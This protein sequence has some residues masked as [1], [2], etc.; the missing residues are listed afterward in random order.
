MAPNGLKASGLSG[1]IS[2]LNLDPRPLWRSIGGPRPLRRC[3]SLMLVGVFLESHGICLVQALRAETAGA[4]APEVTKFEPVNTTDMVNLVTGDFAYT[5][6]VLNVPGPDGGY[7]LTLGYHAGIPHA[8]DASWVGLGWNLQAGSISRAVRGYPDDFKDVLIDINYRSNLYESYSISASYMGV[9][10]GVGYTTYMGFNGFVGYYIGLNLGLGPASVNAGVGITASFSSQ[11]SSV[12]AFAQA[13]AVLGPKSIGASTQTDT[14]G[15]SS[16]GKHNSIGVSIIQGGGANEAGPEGDNS[17]EDTD[18]AKKSEKDSGP[19]GDPKGASASFSSFN[20][21]GSHSKS[22]GLG[23]SFCGFGVNLGYSRS[24]TDKFEH[25]QAY[26]YYYHTEADDPDIEKAKLRINE[27]TMESDPTVVPGDSPTHA[28]ASGMHYLNSADGYALMGEGTGGAL[29]LTRVHDRIYRPKRV[30]DEWEEGTSWPWPNSTPQQGATAYKAR[31]VIEGD[32][33]EQ[34][35]NPGTVGVLP[36]NLSSIINDQTTVNVAQP[37]T[38]NSLQGN[39]P[40]IFWGKE[41]VPGSRVV[42]ERIGSDSGLGKGLFTGFDIWE[43][44]GKH[45]VYGEPVYQFSSTTIS[46]NRP[47]VGDGEWFRSKS[48][49]SQPYAYAWYLTELRYPDYFDEKSDGLSDDDK[50]GWVRFGYIVGCSSYP[51]HT[52]PDGQLNDGPINRIDTWGK[53]KAGMMYSMQYGTKQL[54]YLQSVETAT[55]IALFAVSPRA[56]GFGINVAGTNEPVIHIATEAVGGSSDEFDLTT[57]ASPSKFDIRI[58]NWETISDQTEVV[59]GDGPC[60]GMT[61]GTLYAQATIS[62]SQ[63]AYITINGVPLR[64][65]WIRKTD[66]YTAKTSSA[67]PDSEPTCVSGC[68]TKYTYRIKVSDQFWGKTN[69]SGPNGPRASFPE[70]WKRWDGL[71]ATDTVLKQA[72]M[73][74]LDDI[75]LLEKATGRM[76]KQVHFIYDYLLQQGTVV[77][78]ELKGFVPNT[79]R[80]M[81]DV[82]GKVLNPRGGKLTLIGLRTIGA[83]GVSDNVSVLPP[84]IFEYGKN[85]TWGNKYAFDRWGYFKSDGG[86]WNHRDVNGADQSAWCLTRITTPTGG[87]LQIQYEPKDYTRVQDRYPINP[88]ANAG[89]VGNYLVDLT[90]WVSDCPWP[91]TKDEW[92]AFLA[93]VNGN[94]SQAPT[95][96]RLFPPAG[97]TSAGVTIKPVVS[98][99]SN[100]QIPIE[101]APNPIDLKLWLTTSGNSTYQERLGQVEKLDSLKNIV[102]RQVVSGINGGSSIKVLDASS[103]VVTPKASIN[104]APTT[105]AAV[106]RMV[107]IIFE[108]W[109]AGARSQKR[110]SQPLQGLTSTDIESAKDDDRCDTQV[111]PALVRIARRP[112][113]GADMFITDPG[114]TWPKSAPDAM[115]VTWSTVHSTP[116]VGGGVRVKRILSFDGTRTYNTSYTYTDYMDGVWTSSG[117]AAQEPPPFGFASMDDRVIH[118]EKGGWANERGGGIYHSRVVVR[119]SW[120]EDPSPADEKQDGKPTQSSPTGESVFRFITPKDLPHQEIDLS[121]HKTVTTSDG[122][123]VTNATHLTDILNMGNWWG[124]LLWKEDRDSR[125]RALTRVEN[126]YTQLE[127]YLRLYPEIGMDVDYERAW[128]QGTRPDMSFHWADNKTRRIDDST[129]PNMPLVVNMKELPAET[130]GWEL[131]NGLPGYVNSSINVT[132]VGATTTGETRSVRT[133]YHVKPHIYTLTQDPDTPITDPN[134]GGTTQE[135]VNGWSSSLVGVRE[136]TFA[137]TTSEVRSYGEGLK[138]LSVT[139]NTKWDKRTGVVVEKLQRGRRTGV[140]PSGDPFETDLNDPFRYHDRIITRTWPAY[141]LYP[142]MDLK[143]DP[144]EVGWSADLVVHMLSQTAQETTLRQ[145]ADGTNVFLNSKVTT[146]WQPGATPTMKAWMG[147]GSFVWNGHGTNAVPNPFPEWSSWNPGK[148]ANEG[149]PQFHVSNNWIFAGA[150]TTYDAFAHALEFVEGDGVYSC[151][152]Y[153]YPYD[154]SGRYNRFDN[155]VGDG[156]LPAGTQP[157]AKFVNARNDE[158]L[159]WNFEGPNHKPDGTLDGML[160]GDS[161]ATASDP[162]SRLTAAYTGERAHSGQIP[163]PFPKIA[164]PDGFKGYELRYFVKATNKAL[165][166]SSC[167][168]PVGWKQATQA[169]GGWWFVRT[170]F[171]KAEL[172]SGGTADLNG[173]IDDIVIKPWRGRNGAPTSVSHFAYD[174]ALGLVT[175][176]TGSNGRTTRYSYDNLGRLK[177]AYDV[178]GK[179]TAATRYL[180]YSTLNPKL[181]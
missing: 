165:A 60:Q 73:Q 58:A 135:W 104:Q 173:L 96:F 10:A 33:S 24:W 148:I 35:A 103:A 101:S 125:G 81:T 85:P 86:P 34:F 88:K 90:P 134:E 157:I 178:F 99:L 68:L 112:E 20:S 44:D 116:K 168:T 143:G 150:P 72:G 26:G 108:Y 39:E 94:G 31:F 74:R 106:E 97:T 37:L 159:Y 21:G 19:G 52:S 138:L 76:V 152:K 62:P 25:E 77:G 50:G 141:A 98:T 154:D 84:F 40:S 78:N 130:L 105:T 11:G 137:P 43:M 55:H 49:I 124:M 80:T 8:E 12:T 15:H 174:R 160:F 139:R 69:S 156:F 126:R 4:T 5:I 111:C 127:G 32:N 171:T 119:N 122:K 161:H 61:R 2:R 36:E 128:R 93:K 177:V 6:P 118:T 45:Y 113:G 172:P 28:L 57:T 46:A 64:Y 16:S 95:P 91:D 30:V 87:T 132:L 41:I 129:P 22:F 136:I 92:E 140:V 110:G 123:T 79:D 70:I 18:S 48:T 1:K 170:H 59:G 27:W 75:Y 158:T 155:T 7:P 29:K 114:F 131:P 117:V 120:S 144:T 109:S 3:I 179:P 38:M 164:Q 115:Y 89:Q 176:I 53:Q 63:Q 163:V 65:E 162:I 151:T 47:T 175:S 100:Q 82:D 9:T 66:E 102:S 71:K 51:W 167:K 13:S 121:Y 145:R 180:N 149:L 169:E 14:N 133:G 67:S 147:G 142:D 166:L 107:N 83:G 42:K 153:G 54:K 146:W 23:I 56:D 181:Q 17:K